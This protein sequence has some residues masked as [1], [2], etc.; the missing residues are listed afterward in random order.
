MKVLV[1][2]IGWNDGWNKV[3]STKAIHS[4]TSGGLAK[5]KIIVDEA[6]DD[7]KPTFEV[8]GVPEAKNLAQK[9]ADLGAVVSCL[10][11]TYNTMPKPSPLP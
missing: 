7:L 2:I 9:L 3:E 10:D 1:Q 8:E 11:V 4:A 5:A 6:L